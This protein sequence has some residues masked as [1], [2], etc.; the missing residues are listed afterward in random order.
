MKRI[1]RPVLLFLIMG[2]SSLTLD[3]QDTIN[4]ITFL[5]PEE[6]NENYQ[7]QQGALLLDARMANVYRKYRIEGAINVESK[8][9]L[10]ALSDTLDKST[11]IYLH[12]YNKGRATS[13]AEYLQEEGFTDLH[14]MEGGMN[15]WKDL[16][17]PLDKKKLK[18]K[19]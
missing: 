6:F 4:E 2:F 9:V 13:S 7:D 19:F 12:C 10:K 16:K 1:L 5:G 14:V 17:M 3:G 15:A 11:P 8:E 18:K